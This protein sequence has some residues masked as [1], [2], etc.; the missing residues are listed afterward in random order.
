[1]TDDE[2]TRL[3]R[4]E[5][6]VAVSVILGIVAATWSQRIVMVIVDLLT[7]PALGA[8]W[9]MFERLAEKIGGLLGV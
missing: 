9:V 4:L 3:L 2:E 8:L 1:M 6:T 5:K 7:G